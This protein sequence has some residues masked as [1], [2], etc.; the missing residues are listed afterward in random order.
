MYRIGVVGHRPEYIQDIS[1]TMATVNR[2]VDL[3]AFQYDDLVIN[4]GGEIGVDQW[5]AD[6]CRKNKIRYHMFLPCPPN[7]LGSEWYDDQKLLLDSC[8]KQAWATTICSSEYGYDVEKTNYNSIIDASDFI[9]C[10]WNGMKQGP[11]FDCIN[12]ALEK[13]KLTLNGLDELK[14]V[15]NASTK[16]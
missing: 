16:V 14:L 10:F 3:I 13:N 7:I 15:T 12:Y 2:A 11:T 5:V 9:I 4:V 1:S 8:H 6:F